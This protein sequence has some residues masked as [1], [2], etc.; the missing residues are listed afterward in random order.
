MLLETGQGILREVMIAP[1]IGSLRARQ[2]G[3]LSGALIVLAITFA[4]SRWLKAATP[5]AQWIVGGFWVALTVTFEVLVGRASRA[6]WQRMFSDYD[7]AQGGFLLLGLAV[8][9]AAPWLVANW[10]KQ[11]P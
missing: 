9:F 4:I 2:W 1:V 7:P 3:V 11:R 8:M 6:S 10:R 5:R